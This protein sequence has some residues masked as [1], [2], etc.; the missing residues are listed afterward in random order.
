LTWC[1]RRR[2]LK[3]LLLIILW[4]L[5]RIWCL[6]IHFLLRLKNIFFHLIYFL[7]FSFYPLFSKPWSTSLFALI[8]Q[9]R[10]LQLLICHNFIR[11]WWLLRRTRRFK[12]SI[13][14]SFNLNSFLLIKRL[15]YW[16]NCFL[17]SSGTYLLWFCLNMNVLFR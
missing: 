16:E 15:F 7:L 3:N 11:F 1:F 4:L 14:S 17:F 10:S 6:F 2:I 8:R 5:R 9:W 13:Y 12:M